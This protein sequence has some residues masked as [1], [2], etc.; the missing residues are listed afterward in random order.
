[1]N[2]K[3]LVTRISIHTLWP[4]TWICDPLDMDN[5]RLKKNGP[6]L[7]Y[8]KKGGGESKLS[9]FYDKFQ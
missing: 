6:H 3:F 1:M 2:S 4:K 8:F 7:P 9:I 5:W